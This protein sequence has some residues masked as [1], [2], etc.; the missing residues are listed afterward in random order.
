MEPSLTASP[1]PAEVFPLSPGPLPP[2]APELLSPPDPS[3]QALSDFS[4]ARP[5]LG[6]H[7]AGLSP[8]SW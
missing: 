4:S 2:Q 8:V 1:L 3:S 5:G 6:L 7:A